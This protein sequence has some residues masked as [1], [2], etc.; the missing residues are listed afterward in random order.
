MNQPDKRGN[1]YLKGIPMAKKQSETSESGFPKE[2]GKPATGALTEAGY[3]QL[4][5]LTKI[6]EKQLLNL[7]GVGPK[8]VGILKSTLAAKGLAFADEGKQKE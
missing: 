8:A 6:S 7:H 2:I 1:K 5:E 3:T 4:E